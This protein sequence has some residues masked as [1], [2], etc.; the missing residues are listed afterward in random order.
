MAVWQ[1]TAHTTDH[2][3]AAKQGPY[4][5]AISSPKILKFL[6][7]KSEEWA[8]RRKKDKLEKTMLVSWYFE[9]NQPQRMTSRLKTMCNLSP[10]YSARKSS[11]HKLSI[12]HKIS[13]DTNLHKTKHT[14]T[15]STTFLKN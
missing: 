9:T 11:N 4:Q 12:N 3:L 10:T 5:K 2:Y 7:K 13:P 1:H 8:G 15:S 14:Q 6:E